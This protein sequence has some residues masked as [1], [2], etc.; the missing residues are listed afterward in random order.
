MTATLALNRWDYSTP[1]TF[2]NEVREAEAMGYGMALVGTNATRVWDPY[3]MLTVAALRSDSIALSTFVEN[4]VVR[5]PAVIANSIASVDVVSG[6]RAA[7]GIGVGDTAVRFLGLSPLRVSELEESTI[8][9]RKLLHGDAIDFGGGR[10][11]RMDVARP[12]PVWVAAGGPKALR[13]AGRSAD[14]VYIRVGRHPANLRAAMDAV[15][16]GAEE[17]GRSMDDVRIGLVL[18]TVTVQDADEIR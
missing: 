6:G 4:A 12:V 2:A 13:A 9:I 17:A 3:V 15:R 11:L 18:H 14:G 16:A 7:L 8:A 1:D 10:A 5:H